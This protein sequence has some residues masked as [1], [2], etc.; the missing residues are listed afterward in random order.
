MLE[1]GDSAAHYFSHALINYEWV[2]CWDK[3][4]ACLDTCLD[5]SPG[6]KGTLLLLGTL[7]ETRADRHIWV[8]YCS[9]SANECQAVLVT[10]LMNSDF[11]KPSKYN[12]FPYDSFIS[13]HSR[14]I[15]V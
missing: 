4:F 10:G 8:A 7:L 6:S 11:L 2:F 13:F 14:C 12:V 1:A 9:N 3:E 15:C 5:V